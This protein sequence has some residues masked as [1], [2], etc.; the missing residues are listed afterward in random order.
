MAMCV[1]IPIYIQIN[2][3]AMRLSVCTYQYFIL[4]KL[5]WLCLRKASF[6]YTMSDSRFDKKDIYIQPHF[7]KENDCV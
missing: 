3:Q 4:K 2:G 6:C 7:D 5:L 1:G